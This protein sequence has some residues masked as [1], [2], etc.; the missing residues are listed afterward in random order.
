MLDSLIFFL[1]QTLMCQWERYINKFP[2]K[3]HEIQTPL[4]ITINKNPFKSIRNGTDRTVQN[5]ASSVHR[6]SK[7]LEATDT[8]IFIKAMYRLG[9]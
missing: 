4:E 5:G 1:P 8:A 6:Y 7:M 9:K 2:Y 3:Y